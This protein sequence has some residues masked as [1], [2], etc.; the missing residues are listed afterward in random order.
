MHAEK[1]LSV[2][3]EVWLLAL[4]ARVLLVANLPVALFDVKNVEIAGFRISVCVRDLCAALAVNPGETLRFSWMAI[5]CTGSLH[6]YNP[7]ESCYC[8][9]WRHAVLLQCFVK[10]C[11]CPTSP[12]RGDR[13]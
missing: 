3:R 2:A 1:L 11:M 7:G 10:Y 12:S 8:R 5:G 9:S 13:A 6:M 4:M